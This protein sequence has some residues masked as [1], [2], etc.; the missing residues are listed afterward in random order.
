MLHPPDVDQGGGQEPAHAEIDDQSA[1][2]DLDDL[3]LDRLARLRGRFDAAPRL[4]E[5]RALLGQ[6]QA[7]VLVLLGEDEGVDLLAQLDLVGGIHGLADRELV[8]GDDALGLVADVDQH[9][10]GVDAHDL[11]GDHVALL[12]GGDRGVVIGDDLAV[13]LEQ[14]AI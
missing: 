12:E 5:A 8:G 13:D 4:L 11:A 2:D 14:E 3:A 9:L 1:L 7:P 10:V 6:D